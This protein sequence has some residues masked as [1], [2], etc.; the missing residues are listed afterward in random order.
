MH[1]CAWAQQDLEGSGLTSK[2]S[3]MGMAGRSG[4][5]DGRGG[6]DSAS[7]SPTPSTLSALR[8]PPAMAAGAG[9]GAGAGMGWGAG[10]GAGVDAG[11]GAGVGVGVGATA[12]PLDG[13]LCAEA[14]PGAPAA[15][16]GGGLTPLGA[17]ATAAGG[18]ALG[19]AAG[20]PVAVAAVAASGG[21]ASLP[22]STTWALGLLSAPPPGLSATAPA[23]AAATSGDA[24]P[25]TASH[26]AAA[27][28]L[29]ATAPP[30][31]TSSA[32]SQPLCSQPPRSP[33]SG[34]PGAGLKPG[35]CGA[36]KPSA[37][38]PL[39]LACCGEPHGECGGSP[40][41][42]SGATVSAAFFV[43]SGDDGVALTGEGLAAGEAAACCRSA[44]LERCA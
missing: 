42:A 15:A 22:L 43:G 16:A 33:S 40:G 23:A 34:V 25:D 36:P 38:S 24:P 37:Q 44:A 14:T 5:D 19:G 8:A 6:R 11:A 2:M 9:G 32:R 7:W 29:L 13:T 27:G 17:A 12:A 39:A 26:C 21:E 1:V 20:A 18:V 4:K 3:G 10:V 41:A 35:P 28:L 31:S 30:A